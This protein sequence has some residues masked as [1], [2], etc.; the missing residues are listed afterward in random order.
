MDQQ[1]Q[2]GPLTEEGPSMTTPASAADHYLAERVMTASPAELT[3]M[4]YDA[5]VGAMKSALRLQEAG[6]HLAATPRL[7]KAQDIVLELRTTLNPAAGELAL[8]LDALYTFAWGKLITA[9]CKRD[10]S[11][12]RAAL[13]V[14]E[15][16]QL[17]WRTSC[18]NVAAA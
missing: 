11:A 17:A 5:C 18:L 3:A 4:L 16:L 8:S 14:V 9:S 10:P 13:E 6:E 15:P 7:V 1:G 2:D 12:T